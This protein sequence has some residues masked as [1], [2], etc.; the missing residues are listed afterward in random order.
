MK[1]RDPLRR[2]L[3]KTQ[4][5]AP[6]FA[7]L[8]LALGHTASASEQFECLIEPHLLIDVSSSEIGV[9][10][11][12]NVDAS[13]HVSKDD[14]IAALR[15][16]V[17][18]AT[19]DVSTSRAKSSSELELL[20]REH[21]YARRQLKRVDVLEAESVISQQEVD[22]VRTSQ[23]AAKL[24]FQAASEKQ[25]IAQLE[26]VRDELA[27]ARRIVRSPID[28]VVTRRYKS[29]GEYVD[30]D[31]ILQLAQLD[32][33][34]IRVIVPMTMF[35]QIEVG[36]QA[37]IEPEL[38]IDGPF[39]ATVTT[40]D[41]IV[42]AATATLGVR[43]SLPNPDYRVPAGLK[44]N[45]TL[46]PKNHE[47]ASEEQEG[48]STANT[49][50]TLSPVVTRAKRD[51]E[52]AAAMVRDQAA[53]SVQKDTTTKHNEPDRVAINDTPKTQRAPSADAPSD[54]SCLALGSVKTLGEAEAI[55]ATLSAE[56][57]RFIRQYASD[58]TVGPWTVLSQ[59]PQN[60]PDSVIDSL[61]EAG[62]TDVQLFK[63]GYWAG[64][65]SFGVYGNS[66]NARKHKDRL[67]ALGFDTELIP[68][69]D[70]NSGL[71]INVETL[72]SNTAHLTSIAAIREQF[73]ELT[74]QSIVCPSF[75]GF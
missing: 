17:E 21:E 28:G 7:A 56:N 62:I 25:K 16:E 15:T 73:P 33:L 35:G 39:I 41:P 29:I 65:L 24:R 44:C 68:R 61:R 32:P 58:H 6:W 59:K 12:V 49:A 55:A 8:I 52:L 26:A 72:T 54:K 40:I 30:G 9:L 64:R 46:L 63:R 74:S 22:E 43:L 48:G 2:P 5:L 67:Q 60:D 50:L 51:P 66:G 4:S 1:L 3:C 34:R 19:Y 18:H 70:V 38:P 37:T 31:P 71:D 42:D 45:L 69:I 47:L 57:I 75:E 36:M 23:N 11:S 53:D 27:L 14:V 10:A 13:D 20:K